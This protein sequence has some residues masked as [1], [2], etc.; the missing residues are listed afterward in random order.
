VDKPSP[1]P[2]L[3]EGLKGQVTARVAKRLEADPAFGADWAWT[4][5]PSEWKV[6]AGEET[7]TVRADGGVVTAEGLG[8]TCLLA[9]KCLH[10]LAVA[11]SLPAAT[12]S[13]SKIDHPPASEP[14]AAAGLAEAL[15]AR[16]TPRIAKKLDDPIWGTSWAWTAV[17]SATWTVAP[18]P[19]RS[20]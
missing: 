3:V 19:R 9:P 4:G 2:G 15:R 10:V 1:A 20:R 12:P 14:K 16:V 18:K 7:V 11:R 6:T 8:C 13:S 5:G 17:D